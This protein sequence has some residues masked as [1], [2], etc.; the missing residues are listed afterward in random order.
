MTKEEF[1]SA[2]E[3]NKVIARHVTT[4]EIAKITPYAHVNLE[5]DSGTL[6]YYYSINLEELLD[7]DIPGDTLDDIKDQGWAFDE[8]KENIIIY[9]KV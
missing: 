8:K 5:I 1:K 9:L 6:D 4:A 2:I 3:D 7:S